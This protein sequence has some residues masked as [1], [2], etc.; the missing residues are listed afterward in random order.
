V[1]ARLFCVVAAAGLERE[2]L[3]IGPLVATRTT[4]PP[5]VSSEKKAEMKKKMPEIAKKYNARILPPDTF[6]HLMSTE[7]LKSVAA[8]DG[9]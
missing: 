4:P 3:E 9:E 6:S 7:E 1:P 2:F 5:P 8:A